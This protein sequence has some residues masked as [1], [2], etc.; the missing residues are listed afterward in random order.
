MD[1][2]R[3]L[4]RPPSQRRAAGSRGLRVHEPARPAWLSLDKEL[5]DMKEGTVKAD[6]QDRLAAMCE[7]GPRALLVR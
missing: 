3:S 4:A 1:A 6:V 2:L 5:A 7:Q